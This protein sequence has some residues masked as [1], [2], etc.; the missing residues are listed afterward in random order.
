MNDMSD[1]YDD[2]GKYQVLKH[3]MET[4]AEVAIKQFSKAFG[5]CLS[6]E[7]AFCVAQSYI[8]ACT[9]HACEIIT[10]LGLCELDCW[11]IIGHVGDYMDSIKQDAE[12]QK[13]DQY[14]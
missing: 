3:E 8:Q 12:Y 9:D 5:S 2:D 13:L 11:A 6:N 7:L 10:L 4:R 14:L 1:R